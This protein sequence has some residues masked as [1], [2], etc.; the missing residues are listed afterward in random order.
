[1]H[2]LRATLLDF[3]KACI[4]LVV[5]GVGAASLS[6]QS[7]WTPNSLNSWTPPSQNPP[8]G[9]AAAPINVSNVSQWKRGPLF[10][11]TTAT[12]SSPLTTTFDVLGLA[13]TTMLSTDNLLVSK[14]ATFVAAP[15]SG[16]MKLLSFTTQGLTIAD[17]TQGLGKVLTSDASGL[18]TWQTP[19]APTCTTS[20]T[21][22]GTYSINLNSGNNNHTTQL[23][24]GNLAPGTYKIR[25]NGTWSSV[26]GGGALGLFYDGAGTWNTPTEAPPGATAVGTPSVYLYNVGEFITYVQHYGGTSGSWTMAS[27]SNEATFTLSSTLNLYASAGQSAMSGSASLSRLVNSCGTSTPAP[28]LSCS[29]TPVQASMTNNTVYQNTSGSNLIVV[30]YGSQSATSGQDTITG[31]ISSTNSLTESNAVAKSAYNSTNKASVTFVVPPNYYYK[32]YDTSTNGPVLK[33]QAWQMC[34]GGASTAPTAS[35]PSLSDIRSALTYT[36]SCSAGEARGLTN[37]SCSAVCSSGKKVV[38]GS[39]VAKTAAGTNAWTPYPINSSVPS[40]DGTSWDCNGVSPAS[41]TAV[42]VVGNAVCI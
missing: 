35:T 40:S 12:L 16:P 22:I 33:S 8:A 4:L 37:A 34:G 28:A 42:M 19:A 9:N 20:E 31:Y 2:Q 41:N 13:S 14:A 11:G 6:A 27:G 39:C 32:T 1:M 18:A 21:P 23:L 30:A 26:G 24:V 38:S 36:A 3:A 15:L 7:N 25:G 5:I 10:I 17:G 29:A